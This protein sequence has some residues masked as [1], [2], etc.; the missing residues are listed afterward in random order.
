[1]PELIQTFKSMQKTEDEKRKFLAMLQ[2][3][4]LNEEV[5]E[6]PS[7]DDIRRKALGINATADDVVSLQGTFANEAGFGIGA[8]LGYT[9]IKE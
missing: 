9:V 4:N 2:G 5:K 8:G 6:G 1:M 3:I 7:F